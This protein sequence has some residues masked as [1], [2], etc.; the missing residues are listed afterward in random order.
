MPSIS[1]ISN[2][3]PVLGVSGESD[4]EGDNESGDESEGEIGSDSS[5]GGNERRY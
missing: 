1:N 3:N 2:E 4:G 5:S